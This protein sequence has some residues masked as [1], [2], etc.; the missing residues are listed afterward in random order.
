MYKRIP[1]ILFAFLVPLILMGQDRKVQATW[2]VDGAK[3]KSENRS[4]TA[5]E[6]MNQ[7]QSVIFAT[8]GVELFLTRLRINKTSGASMDE[9]RRETGCNSAILADNGSQVYLDYCDVTSHSPQADGVTG[10]GNGTQV[11]LQE[12]TVSTTRGA[13]VAISSIH[14]AKVIVNKTEFSTYGNQSPAFFALDEGIMEITEA[15]G[16]NGGQASP[17]FHSSGVMHGTKCRVSSAKWTIGNVEN[18][19]LFLNKNELKSGGISGF[20]LYSTKSS[21]VQSMLNLV[22]NTISV[23]E[24]PL[25]LVTNN[26]NAS[27]TMTGNRI[28]CKSGELMSVRSDDWGVKGAN[29]GHASLWVEKQNL[30]GEIFVDSISSL[31][32]NLKKGAKLNGQINKTE[33]RCAKVSVKLSAG[34]SWTSKGESYLTSIE[35][36]QPL[37]KGLKQL[38]GNH[39]IYYDPSDPANAPLEGKEYK[40]GGGRLCPLK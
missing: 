34:S 38:K 1:V 28:S 33:N 36:D 7:G 19:M 25:I 3:V 32:V 11:I 13:S 39:T 9:D 31:Q 26:D 12:G 4:H 6:S 2:Y 37:P 17:V 15:S 27:I 24:G 10:S 21:D 8:N 18:G 14:G 16:E 30:S 40:T 29:G 5:L 35:F 22:K 20:L 23:A